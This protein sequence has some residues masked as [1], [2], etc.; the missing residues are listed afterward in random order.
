MAAGKGATGF[1][2]E[3]QMGGTGWEAMALAGVANIALIQRF[4]C[5]CRPIY[6]TTLKKA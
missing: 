4:F 2:G 1:K 3:G 6:L 5:I